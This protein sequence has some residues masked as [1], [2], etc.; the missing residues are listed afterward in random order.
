M[1]RVLLLCARLTV[2]PGIAAS[3]NDPASRVFN[4]LPDTAPHAE[5][6]FGRANGYGFELMA[7]PIRMIGKGGNAQGTSAQIEWYP[8]SGYSIIVLSNYDMSAQ[9]A[10]G[11]IREL[12]LGLK[13]G[14]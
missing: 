9:V 2:T 5:L 6:P 10:A 3:Q 4:T 11:G 1:S 8:D 7:E 13:P 12:V 14:T